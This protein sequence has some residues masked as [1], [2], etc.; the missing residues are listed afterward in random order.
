[1]HLCANSVPDSVDSCVTASTQVSIDMF[2]KNQTVTVNNDN[3]HSR[4]LETVACN[5]TSSNKSVLTLQE[6][7]KLEGSKTELGFL[8][9][10]VMRLGVNR[11]M[12]YLCHHMILWIVM[13]MLKRMIRI[14]IKCFIIN[15]F[16]KCPGPDP[17]LHLLPVDQWAIPEL[18]SQYPTQNWYPHQSLVFD[19]PVQVECWK[20][21][22]FY[23]S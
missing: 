1:M 15:M 4:E 13:M 10:I 8:W 20:Q 14:L 18:Q 5:S 3:Q 6:N 19:G 23:Q 12:Q 17:T 16:K 22:R 2:S 7:D 21:N 11:T 9:G